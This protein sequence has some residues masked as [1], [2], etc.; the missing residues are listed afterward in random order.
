VLQRATTDFE[1]LRSE[2]TELPPTERMSV[3]GPPDPPDVE[4]VPAGETGR[5]LTAAAAT[6]AAE[7][8]SAATTSVAAKDDGGWTRVRRRIIGSTFNPRSVATI[9]LKGRKRL[10]ADEARSLINTVNKAK[11]LTVTGQSE[12]EV[13]A[14]LIKAAAIGRQTPTPMDTSSSSSD[15]NVIQTT[16]APQA[17]SVLPTTVAPKK[18]QIPAITGFFPEAFNHLA[19]AR[20]LTGRLNTPPILARRGTDK[21]GP[22]GHLQV[23]VRVSIQTSSESDFNTTSQ[24]LKAEG[25]EFF[26][27]RT[28][29]DRTIKV[30]IR[31]LM[32]LTPP[33]EVQAELC[34]KGFEVVSA[35]VMRSYRKEPMPMFLVELRDSATTPEIYNLR[36][37][38]HMRVQVEAYRG[39]SGPRQCHN[40]CRFGHVTSGC[41]ALP[42][43]VKCAGAHHTSTCSKTDL[44]VPA[45][46]ANCN[47]R[48]TASYRACPVFK[49][50][51]IAHKARLQGLKPKAAP[52]TLTPAPVPTH[53]VW[54]R[55]SAVPNASP[56]A[57]PI[58]AAKETPPVKLAAAKQPSAP[59][60][61]S[62]PKPKPSAPARPSAPPAQ[63]PKPQREKAITKPISNQ[64]PNTSF[65]RIADAPDLSPS[66]N[67]PSADAISALIKRGLE[68]L[69][70][71]L[72][73]TPNSDRQAL[74]MSTLRFVVEAVQ[75]LV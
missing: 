71:K 27:F 30:V 63:A 16:S 67:Q 54:D 36:T 53:N 7:A 68:L 35:A 33:E 1:F 23:K 46:C 14:L 15:A 29:S 55:A 70:M 47:E 75:M 2:L 45:T 37:L 11:R 19:F 64:T 40:C 52:V 60:T 31:N 21:R 13:E 57:E 5:P 56:T 66:E 26:V 73:L 48:H 9:P 4:A 49:A 42:R 65:M 32:E 39:P 10:S 69:Q 25:I 41:N 28:L 43:C 8:T 72:S 59:K 38:L 3:P 51:S 58:P 44:S 62:A 22:P 34:S 50:A 12:A 17:S 24:I 61:P 20:K 18:R 74:A 6:A